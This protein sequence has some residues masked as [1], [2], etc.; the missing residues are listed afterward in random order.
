MFEFLRRKKTRKPDDFKV[1]IPSCNV[2][3]EVVHVQVVDKRN[4]GMTFELSYA[5]FSIDVDAFFKDRNDLT[6]G[7][8]RSRGQEV[9]W[10]LIVEDEVIAT[11]EWA[12]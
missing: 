9:S 5:N 4:F 8:L 7:V 10:E 6:F 12:S 1:I 11:G 2:I 3:Q